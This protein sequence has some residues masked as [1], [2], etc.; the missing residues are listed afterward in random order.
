MAE[1]LKEKSITA[2]LWVV[3]DKLGGTLVSFIVTVILARLL[4][5]KDFGLLALV[6]VFFEFSMVFVE[7]GF[8]PALIREKKLTVADKST[9]F[10]FNLVSACVL[11]G[12]LFLV[13]PHISSFYKEPI[14]T[15]VIRVLGLNIIISSFSIVQRASLIHRV[16]FRTQT[17]IRIPAV[18]ISGIIA[19]YMAFTGFGIWS[20][21]AQLIVKQTVTA[22]SLWLYNPWLPRW[23]FSRES[24]TRLFGIGSKILL[25]ALL[26]KF[27]KNIY[28]LLIGKFFSA[29]VLGFYTQA[30]TFVNMT[31]NHLYEGVRNVS[32]PVLTKMQDDPIRLK[33]GYRKFIRLTS[34]AIIPAIVLLAVLA[35]PLILSL[36]G[37]K[38]LPTVPFLRLLCLSGV[39]FHFSNINFNVLLVLGRVD[40]S[41]KLEIIKKVNITIGILI[42]IQFG[43]YGLIIGQ[44]ISAYVDLLLNAYY[45]NKLLGYPLRE[46]ILDI[47]QCLIFG[48]TMGIIVWVT[49]AMTAFGDRWSLA[50]G[51][52]LGGLLYLGFHLIAKTEEI[53]TIRSLILPRTLQFLGRKPG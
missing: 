10:I 9:T 50:I 16:D 12:I 52:V 19:I 23:L 7:S 28:Y 3:I 1:G 51:L 46:Q 37:Q 35:E 26:D 39:T 31:V 43:I 25:M 44:V 20:L 2:F 29:S 5:P 14:L 8:S 48:F 30:N 22:I 21:V 49:N 24:F 27:Y 36:L 17:L 11:Y 40:I 42:G 15:S 6:V 18:F 41:L 34:F 13:A 38:W 32:Y 47:S 4:T 45:S 53:N 33:N